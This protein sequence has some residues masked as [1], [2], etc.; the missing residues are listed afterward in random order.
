MKW[1]CLNQIND[2]DGK[3]LFEEQQTYAEAD[4][5]GETEDD[6]IAICLF[7]ELGYRTY[8]YGRQVTDNFIEQN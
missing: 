4:D 2:E 5:R 7:N 1:I 3:V 8:L 6:S